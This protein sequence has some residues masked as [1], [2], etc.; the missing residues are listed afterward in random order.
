MTQGERDCPHKLSVALSSVLKVR[1]VFVDTLG[2][3]IINCMESAS[4]RKLKAFGG[5]QRAS[6]KRQPL[7][8]VSPSSVAIGARRN[9]TAYSMVLSF[10]G[11]AGIL[12]KR[13]RLASRFAWPVVSLCLCVACAVLAVRAVS[14]MDSFAHKV[15]F[16]PSE[17]ESE[18]TLL[19]GDMKTLA[20]G[21]GFNF[22]SEGNVFSSDGTL[23]ASSLGQPGEVTGSVSFQQYTVRPGDTISGICL[24]FGLSNISTLIQ[25]NGIKNVRS[26]WSGQ[27][28][29]VP[30]MDGIIHTVLSGET[31]AAIATRYGVTVEDLLDA[32]D[33]ASESL[34]VG[35]E[36][37][38][39]GARLDTESLRRAMGEV[40]AHPIKDSYRLSSRFGPRI[41]P[42][43]GRKSSHTGTDFACPTGT[44]I[45][46]SMSG[47]V[48]YTGFSSI[49]GN[50]VILNHHDGYQTLYAHMSKIIAKKGSYVAQG[51]RIGLVGS[52]GYSTGPHLH[53]T[54]Y[55]DSALVD[56]MTLLH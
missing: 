34:Q 42:I 18:I 33:L 16:A 35:Q 31:L 36:L 25:V 21:K 26:I 39:P 12:T 49:Y 11:Q 24:K 48:A 5:P 55:K 38:V 14:Y 2:M 10:K 41:D 54:V 53:F 56:P 43:S 20:G 8:R 29:K 7:K 9:T 46:A 52:T 17:I 50:Y 37:F 30:S 32:N 51:E 47:K 6:A 27:R 22:D 1:R 28:L 19:E 15:D 4:P 3:E 40:F 13:V 44:P 45:Y 23:L